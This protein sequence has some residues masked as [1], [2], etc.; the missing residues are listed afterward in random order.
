M[1]F[2]RTLRKRKWFF[3]LALALFAGPFSISTI[4]AIVDPGLAEIV[5]DRTQLGDVGRA[6]ADEFYTTT[7]GQF[8]GD[9]SRMAGFYVNNN[10]GIAFR[11]FAYGA[12]FG[13]GSMFIL[14]FNGIALGTITGFIVSEGHAAN[15]FSF[16]LSHG[17]FELTAIVI[18]WGGWSADWTWHVVSRQPDPD[19]FAS[20]ARSRCHQAR[21]WRGIDA[22][23]RCLDRSGFLANTDS[24]YRQ[25]HCRYDPVDNDHPVFHAGRVGARS[26]YESRRLHFQR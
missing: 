10:V 11:C 17:S 13:I 3:Y 23:G 26:P 22:C 20:R 9:R 21:P 14:L 8:V 1:G 25:I 19:G 2:P 16:V 5:M 12:F 24:R 6:Y 15:F 7:D 18:F 4:V